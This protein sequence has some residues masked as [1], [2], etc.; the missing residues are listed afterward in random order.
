VQ[1]TVLDHTGEA[2]FL[3]FDQDVIKLIHKSAYELLEQ[4]VQVNLLNSTI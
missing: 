4:Q 3:L 1:V 2:S